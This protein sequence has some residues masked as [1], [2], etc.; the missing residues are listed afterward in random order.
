MDPPT[1]T[2]AP[3]VGYWSELL[4]RLEEIRFYLNM[5]DAIT[6]KSETAPHIQIF[7]DGSVVFVDPDGIATPME[8]SDIH[9]EPS[10]DD[11]LDK[12]RREIDLRGG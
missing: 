8:G 6:P 2:G 7:G 9:P 1:V 5:L 3:I 10:V 4:E 12:I 11:L